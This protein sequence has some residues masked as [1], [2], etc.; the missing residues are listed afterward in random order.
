LYGQL[1]RQITPDQLHWLFS[2]KLVVVTVVGGTRQFLGPVLG[3]ILFV[4]LEETAGRWPY[5][6]YAILGGLLL[7]VGYLAPSGAAGA[8]DAAFARLRSLTAGT[9]HNRKRA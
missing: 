5:G 2:A 6:Q 4:V 9:I 3:A 1:H 8:I 7:L